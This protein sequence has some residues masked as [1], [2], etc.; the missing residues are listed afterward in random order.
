MKKA[1]ALVLCLLFLPTLALA[2]IPD[3]FNPPNANEGQYPYGS[4][5]TSLSWWMVINSGAA[6]FISSYDE[7]PAYALVQ[8][9]TGIDIDFIHPTVG[10]EREQFNLLVASG[11]LP[12]IIQ[13]PQTGYYDGGLKKM[14]EDG[15][16]IELT[17]YLE[18]NAP[19]YLAC[20]NDT[21]IAQK[22]IMQG[23]NGEIYGF[24]RM[25]LAGVVP[26]YR[27]N[28]RADWLEEFGMREPVT[29]A[30][31]EAYFEAVLQNKQG[32]APLYVNFE[33]TGNVNLFLGA[34]D[35]LM[36]FYLQDGQVRHYANSDAYRSFLALMNEWYAKG[37]ISKDFASLTD[38]EV[39][40]MFDSGTLAMY[41][42]SIDATYVRVKDLDIEVT[43][44]PYM[45]M[46]A[47]SI[48]GNEVAN[49]PVDGGVAYVSVI[50]SACKDVE[51]AISLLNYMYTY[52]GAL[53]G[54]WGV[55]GET[56][57]W[58]DDGFPKFTEMYLN[59][60]DGMTTSNCAYALRC[61][62]GSKYT[63]SDLICGLTDPGQIANRTKWVD[64]TNVTD[65]L[66]LPPIN[67]TA[68]E[69]SDRTDLTSKFS[70]YV[71]EMMLKFVTGIEPL[72]NWDS[73]VSTVESMGLLEAI[74][75]TQAAYDRY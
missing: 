34:F 6:N 36:D 5:D 63:Y 45:R 67:L 57:T 38:A 17:P 74:E 49:H 66:R 9:N 20:V 13:L 18:A 52:E 15:L 61:H 48:L 16:I 75:I 47:D 50:T 10:M 12:D 58:G 55:E 70:T 46:E 11:D 43:N 72:D 30:D 59:N 42:D 41:A 7:N 2:Q 68:Q 28:A 40:S 39:R 21:E 71:S 62:L 64:D 51:A 73:Y 1:M 31:Y 33:N 14:Y 56:Y 3:T 32:V 54:N 29:V 69:I 23:D 53:V 27:M 8:E 24:Y 37:Y 4:G 44:C 60:P 65:F 26:H 25:S 22:Q 19:Q 35:N